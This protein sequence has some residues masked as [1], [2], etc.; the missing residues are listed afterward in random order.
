MHSTMQAAA[1][2]P[3]PPPAAPQAPNAHHVARRTFNEAVSEREGLE[4]WCS[5]KEEAALGANTGA[6]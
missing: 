3:A 1:P 5:Y 2:A 6:P 4:G